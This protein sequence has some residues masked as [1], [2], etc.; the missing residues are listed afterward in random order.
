LNN[1]A[2]GKGIISGKI[3]EYLATGRPVL[4]IGDLDSDG[5]KLLIKSGAGCV[6]DYNDFEG[7]KNYLLSVLK[8]GFSNRKN[9]F[10]RDVSLYTRENQAREYAKIIDEVISA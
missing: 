10:M 5:A 4:C 2:H 8:T 6:F 1:T 3:F 7:V 9:R